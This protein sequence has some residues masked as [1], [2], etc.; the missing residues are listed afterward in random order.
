LTRLGLRRFIA[1]LPAAFLGGETNGADGGYKHVNDTL[2]QKVLHERGHILFNSRC[3][4][5]NCKLIAYRQNSCQTQLTNEIFCVFD[6]P[7]SAKKM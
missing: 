4:I 7:L 5:L 6:R 2:D 3:S 1:G